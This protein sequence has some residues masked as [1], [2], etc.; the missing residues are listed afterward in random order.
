[1]SSTQTKITKICQPGLQNETTTT[2]TTKNK[3]PTVL[4]FKCLSNKY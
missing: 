3:L 2:T 1:M 4:V